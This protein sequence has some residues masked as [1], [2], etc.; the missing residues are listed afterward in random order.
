MF[1][2]ATV[3]KGPVLA[4]LLLE[5]VPVSYEDDGKATATLG[6]SLKRTSD[7]MCR[8]KVPPQ[9]VNSDNS[10]WICRGQGSVALVTFV[11]LNGPGSAQDDFG[12]TIERPL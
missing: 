3:R 9:G 8:G 10:V 2:R 4:E 12:T 6:E 1:H 5:S 7:L 11:R